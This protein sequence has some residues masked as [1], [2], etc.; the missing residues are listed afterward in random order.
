MTQQ[1]RMAVI[2]DNE[3][4]LS[5]SGRIG[6]STHMRRID[7]EFVT[8][9]SRLTGACKT[10]APANATPSVENCRDSR[11]RDAP[12]P[13]VSRARYNQKHYAVDVTG[14][15]RSAAII[16]KMFANRSR[17]MAAAIWKTT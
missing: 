17:E 9:L 2:G 8:I 1:S 14:G 5:A 11:H 7:C 6:A 4:F 16:R 12:S 3:G 10:L 13:V 15:G